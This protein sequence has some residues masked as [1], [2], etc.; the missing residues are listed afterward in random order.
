M[1]RIELSGGVTA[2]EVTGPERAPGVV[3]VH[4]MMSPS[5][6]FDATVPALSRAHRVLRYDLFGR[7]GSARP[8]ARYTLELYS[9]QLDELA[10]HVFGDRPLALVGYSWGAGIAAEWADR[11]AERVRQVVLVAPAGLHV[12]LAQR[13]IALPRAGELVTRGARAR[14]VRARRAGRAPG[15]LQPGAG[16]VARG[17]AV[18]L[19]R[20]SA[21]SSGT[22]SAAHR[23]HVAL[24]AGGRA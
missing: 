13:L 22:R 7:G 20:R 23:D 24:R 18:R 6:V 4:G 3:L 12:G 19:E 8:Q 10:R 15:A 9:A 16:A 14:R 11:R 17:R 5:F 2:F 1:E 21:R